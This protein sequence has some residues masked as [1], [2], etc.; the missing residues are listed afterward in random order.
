MVFVKVIDKLYL[1][2]PLNM[3]IITP[4]GQPKIIIFFPNIWRQ[5]SRLTNIYQKVQ[6]LRK[7]LNKKYLKQVTR[8]I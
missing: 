4:S 7:S 1:F 2:F 5:I 6:T 8:Q 3:N